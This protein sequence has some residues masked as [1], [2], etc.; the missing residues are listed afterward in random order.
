MGKFAMANNLHLSEFRCTRQMEA[1]I[2][3]ITCSLFKGGV[4]TVCGVTTNGGTGSIFMAMLAHRELFRSRGKK[5]P[6]VVAAISCHPAFDKAC[7]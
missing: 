6:N 1:E 4:E 3:A 2:V 7:H 5:T